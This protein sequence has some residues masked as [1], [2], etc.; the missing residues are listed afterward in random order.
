MYRAALAFCFFFFV[1][2]VYKDMAI[3]LDLSPILSK[4]KYLSLIQLFQT[5]CYRRK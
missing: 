3:L 1:E 4:G 5:V 2:L